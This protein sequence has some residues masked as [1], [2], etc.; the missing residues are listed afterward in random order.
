MDERLCYR[1]R[2]RGTETGNVFEVV[3]SGFGD[4]FD[5]GLKGEGGVKDDAQVAD[6][7]GWSD[8]TAVHTDE[9]IS[10]L[11]EQWLGGQNHELSLI[12]IEFE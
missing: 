12:A 11:P 10:N 8:G 2:Q 6:L 7:R 9:E 5:V 3:E 4:E 1:V